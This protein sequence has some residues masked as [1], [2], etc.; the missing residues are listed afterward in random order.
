ML[1]ARAMGLNTIIVHPAVILGSTNAK[2][3]GSASIPAQA[4]KK[5]L[6]YTSGVMGY[7]DVM[8]VARAMILLSEKPDAISNNYILCAGNLSYKALICAIRNGA[9]KSKPLGE[10]GYKTLMAVSKIEGFIS[11]VTGHR[12]VITKEIVRNMT[13]EY[14]YDGSKIMCEFNFVYT[15][16]FQ[17][18][19]RIGKEYISKK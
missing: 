17:T 10:I 1:R 8:D 15:P 5:G 13:S 18:L 2:T 14:R 3:S 7:V 6:F 12:V 4:I 11:K 16:I 19:D 9:N